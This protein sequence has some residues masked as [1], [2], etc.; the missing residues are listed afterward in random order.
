MSKYYRGRGNP[1]LW[2]VE[3]LRFAEYCRNYWNSTVK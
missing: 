3:T 2:C 1:V